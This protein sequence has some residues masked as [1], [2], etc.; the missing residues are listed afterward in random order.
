MSLLQIYQ[1]PNAWIKDG[2][3]WTMEFRRNDAWI[4]SNGN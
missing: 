3:T 2:L 4:L 1:L